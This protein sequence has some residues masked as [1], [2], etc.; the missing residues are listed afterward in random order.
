MPWHFLVQP[1]GL[2]A[3]THVELLGA[4]DD[5]FGGLLAA[6]TLNERNEVRRIEGG[7]PR[8]DRPAILPVDVGPLN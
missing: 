6:N 1:D 2:L 7:A 8:H 4:L 5:C 3:Q